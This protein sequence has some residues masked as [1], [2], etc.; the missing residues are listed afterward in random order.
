MML[1][2]A[3]RFCSVSQARVPKDFMIDFGFI[4][5][6]SSNA[7]WIMP[8]SLL[9]KPSTQSGTAA[10]PESLTSP[11]R[12]IDPPTLRFANSAAVLDKVSSL[13]SRELQKFVPFALKAPQGPL[14]EGMQQRLVWREDMAAFVQDRL[15]KLAVRALK[16]SVLADTN[17]NVPPP[18][19]YSLETDGDPDVRQLEQSLCNL[20]ALE[21]M[22]WG[23]VL[24]LGSPSWKQPEFDLTEASLEGNGESLSARNPRRDALPDLIKL[25]DPILKVPVFDLREL[26]SAGELEELRGC[27]SIFQSTAVFFRATLHMTPR[28]LRAL[29]RLKNNIMDDQELSG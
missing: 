23:A 14:T 16:R 28:P 17:P 9:D 8:T 7:L 11:T 12:E 6:P 3:V 1:V 24:V 15:R 10:A 22:T 21:N 20:G 2:A 5:N 29:W 4:K 26:F 13:R 19:W 18:G 27:H 25:P